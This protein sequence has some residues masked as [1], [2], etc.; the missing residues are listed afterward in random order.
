AS[1]LAIIRLDKLTTLSLRLFPPLK[2]FERRDY[3]ADIYEGLGRTQGPT[4]LT[5]IRYTRRF[6]ACIAI[7][8]LICI[9]PLVNK[10]VQGE[11]DDRRSD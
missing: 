11:L 1:S 4:L 10:V 5:F 2:P 9:A 8:G 6:F 3:L 7:Y